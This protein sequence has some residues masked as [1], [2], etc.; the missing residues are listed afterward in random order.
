MDVLTNAIHDLEQT[1]ET[2]SKRRQTTALKQLNPNTLSNRQITKECKWKSEGKLCKKTSPKMIYG[3]EKISQITMDPYFSFASYD[4]E[5]PKE[6]K[7]RANIQTSSLGPTTSLDQ[8]ESES[9]SESGITQGIQETSNTGIW[10]WLTTTISSYNEEIVNFLTSLNISQSSPHPDL[11][12][13]PIPQWERNDQ[14]VPEVSQ[15]TIY[16]P[17]PIRYILIPKAYY[18][19]RYTPS[20]KNYWTYHDKSSDLSEMYLNDYLLQLHNGVEMESSEV[21][22]FLLSD[23]THSQLFQNTRK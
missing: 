16:Q 9:E 14:A 10:S 19:K 3:V 17:K 2:S 13:Q 21:E 7:E 22:E 11:Q 8:S 5:A 20:P 23:T 15:L 18:T 4:L 1:L 6:P 12:N